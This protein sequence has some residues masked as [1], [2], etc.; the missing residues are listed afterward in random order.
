MFIARNYSN[1][2]DLDAQFDDLIRRLAIQLK[3]RMIV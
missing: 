3:K 2:N 1:F